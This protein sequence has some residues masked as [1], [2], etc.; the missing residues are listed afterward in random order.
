MNKPRPCR[1]APP[2]AC[3]NGW[4]TW[5]RESWQLELILSGFAI[6]LL[7]GIYEPLDSLGRPVRQQA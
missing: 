7:I 3:P 5:Y 4:T 6:F 1:N 2:P